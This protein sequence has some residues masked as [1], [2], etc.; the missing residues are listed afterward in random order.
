MREIILAVSYWLH[1]IATVVWIGGIIF[2]LFIVIPSS[3][4][5]LGVESGKLMGEI[6]KRFTPLANYSIIL[7]IIT[8]LVLTGFNKQ[9]SGIGNFKNNWT[10][11]LTVKH[12]LVLGMVIVHF[13]RG[14]VLSPKIV[15]TESMTEKTSLQKLSLNLVKVNFC[16]GLL[17][18]LL[19]GVTSI[20]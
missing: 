12:V 8:G 6:S 3:N 19:S 13:Y 20:L 4:Q 15:K 18:L 10:F 5:L 16:A 7:L 1:L 2:I 17:V 11:V 14:L 9:F